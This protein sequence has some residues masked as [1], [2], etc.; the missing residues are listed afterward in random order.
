[1]NQA[2][3][4]FP[5]PQPC[6][7]PW[8]QPQPQ[9]IFSLNMS[10]LAVKV[11]NLS[12]RYRIGTRPNGYR[13]LRESV[14]DFFSY[15]FK[16]IAAKRAGNS[17]FLSSSTSTFSP[18]DE[19]WALKD[20]SFEVGRGEVVGIIGRNG[21]GKSTLLKILSRITEPT[22]G[23]ADIHG[24]LGALLEV[25]TGI[26]P[27]LT[28]REN[29][30][31]SGAILGMGKKE[32]E[33]KFDA[34][35]A[36]AE[37]ERFIETPVKHY[38][39][40]MT[41]RL[42]FAVA[43]HLEPEILLVD[44]VLAVGDMAFQRKCLGKMDDVAQGGRTILFVSHNMG[45]VRQLCRRVIWLDQGE[46]VADGNPEEVISRYLAESSR[47]FVV[48]QM[49]SD[50]LRIEKVVLQGGDGK[51]KTTFSPGDDLGIEIHFFAKRSI[52]RPFFWVN[53][54]S[55]YGSVFGANML[56]DGHQPAKI[57]GRGVLSCTLK[58]IPLLPQAYSLRMGVRAENG[59]TLLVKTAEVGFFAV[60]G[61]AKDLGWEEERA[62]ALMGSA[63]PVFVPYEWKL[64]GGR[65]V[66]VNPDWNSR[67][68]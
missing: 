53:V 51:P 10:N 54:I 36:F 5:Q 22:E 3:K 44:E 58:N 25:G 20:I 42:A 1:M 50:S 49:E 65:I 66:A 52:P 28:G 11:E 9:P 4:S 56:F 6:P 41:V 12:K 16:K 45:A 32:I 33:R 55:Q 48:T 18:S 23:G 29:V 7:Y 68:E 30:F 2:F 61:K 67:H 15:P 60:E 62:E 63:A 19:L 24:R 59:V 8:P 14:T 47:G 26:H 39:T 38:S 46:I 17:A 64:P 31:L 27:E 57:E 37:V 35:V 13:T 21:A 43:A 40:G 34:I